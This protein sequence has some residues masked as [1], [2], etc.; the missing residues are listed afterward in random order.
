M[1]IDFWTWSGHVHVRVP[2]LKFI[3]ILNSH[4]TKTV[5]SV[6][7]LAIIPNASV[8]IAQQVYTPAS[9]TMTTSMF[10]S[11]VNCSIVSSCCPP[12]LPLPWLK[13]ITVELI[14][15]SRNH[16]KLS[17]LNLTFTVRVHTTRISVSPNET[18]VAVGATMEYANRKR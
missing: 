16:P 12:S 15:P 4:C 11:S 3:L 13:S 14:K 2:H 1:T 8:R 9:V 18:V 17:E 10:R 7:T 5:C 6:V